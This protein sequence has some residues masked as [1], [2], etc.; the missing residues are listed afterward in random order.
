[1]T[2]VPDI[3]IICVG[4]VK[5]P[6]LAALATMYHKRI[7]NEAKIE[8]REIGDGNRTG[9]GEKIASALERLDGRAIALSEEGRTLSSQGFASL[10]ENNG[11]R[12]IFTIGGADG[13]SDRVKKCASEI[14]SLS[15][16]TFTH[17]MAR[18][19]LLEQIYR[20]CSIIHNRSYHRG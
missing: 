6:H 18:V 17:E 20:A 13:L 7:R 15:A 11:R 3:L 12:V 19:I 9:E 5:D 10:L 2:V 8:I 4:A 1:M 14:V 16:L